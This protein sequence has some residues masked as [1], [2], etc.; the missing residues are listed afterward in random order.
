MET[1]TPLYRTKYY[2][3]IARGRKIGIFLATSVKE[4]NRHIRKL[5]NGFSDNRYQRFNTLQEALQYMKEHN[6]VTAAL[7]DKH[8]NKLDVYALRVNIPARIMRRTEPTDDD[9]SCQVCR[10]HVG[11]DDLHPQCEVCE[12]WYHLGC[13]GITCS[14]LPENEYVCE[15]CLCS[16][17]TT[18]ETVDM[19]LTALES[20]ANGINPDDATT[21]VDVQ[22][23]G[24]EEVEDGAAGVF[25]DP[26]RVVPEEDSAAVLED[27]SSRRVL[28]LL[29]QRMSKLEV[30]NS[31][32]KDRINDLE[33]KLQSST[34]SDPKCPDTIVKGLK[35]VTAA[36]E[37]IFKKLENSDKAAKKQSNELLKIKND[38]AR[39]KGKSEG[40][41]GGVVS[42]GGKG[43]SWVEVVRRGH[44]K[45]G[46]RKKGG[47]K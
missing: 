34:D 27:S 8:I 47:V 4:F 21:N 36:K 6:L 1:T 28:N 18:M 2:Y 14:D 19:A 29:L 45:S 39:L 22:T 10:S 44:K 15:G 26:P 38:V 31:Q 3:A 46:K 43:E 40:A 33:K 25:Q 9:D 7:F 32:L 16:V 41:L 12:G 24:T 30:E 42:D 35:V 5:V 23:T 11:E 13:I 20:E 37:I 17:G